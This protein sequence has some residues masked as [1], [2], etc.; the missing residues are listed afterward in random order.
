MKVEQF[1][2]PYLDVPWQD[3][4]ARVLSSGSRIGVTLGYPAAG[5][6]DELARRLAEFLGVDHVDLELDF[7]PPP[8]R[9]PGRVGNIIAVAS[10]KGGVGKSTTAVN[11]AL[12]LDREGARVGL[13]DADIYGPSQGMM[14]GVPPSQRPE[15][16]SRPGKGGAEQK[17]FQPIKA[18]GIQAMSM[19]FLVTEKTP[20]VWRGPMVSGALQ[21]L[22]TQTLW[23][24]LDY[25]IVDMP[26]GTGDI[27]LTLSQQVPVAGAVIVTTPQDIAL[28]DAIKGI[29]MFRKVDIPVLGVIE[30]MS[31]F[32]CPHCGEDS[33]IF[34][35]GGGERIAHE[36][37]TPLLGRLPLTLAIREQADGGT[38]TVAHDPDGDIAG[39]YRDAARRLAAELWRLSGP[40]A[41]AGGPEISMIDD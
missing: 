23:D 31:V 29:E 9:G 6:H 36:F 7:R 35:S 25:L 11:L 19:S 27:Q 28:L 34:G 1:P 3:L 14:L 21:Q 5:M 16:V 10:G 12:A 32:R 2:D 22:L 24:D 37:A 8:G 13:L 18:H 38:P 40:A 33:P 15:V 26:P 30:N 20:M 39:I 17:F 41:A 4:G